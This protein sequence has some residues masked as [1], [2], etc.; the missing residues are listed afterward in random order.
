[1]DIGHLLTLLSQKAGHETLTEKSSAFTGTSKPYSLVHHAG[2]RRPPNP[3][4]SIMTGY[5]DG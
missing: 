2:N 3:E 1:M 5:K 4:R